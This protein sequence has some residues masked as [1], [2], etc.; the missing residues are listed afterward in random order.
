[1]PE[2]SFARLSIVEPIGWRK[3]TTHHYES[4]PL[5]IWLTCHYTLSRENV[6]KCLRKQILSPDPVPINSRRCLIDQRDIKKAAI[7]ATFLRGFQG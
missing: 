3:R 2:W 4:G 5:V 7:I 6:F 1:M